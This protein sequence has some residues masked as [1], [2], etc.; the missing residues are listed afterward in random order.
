MLV[1][2]GAAARGPMRKV[3]VEAPTKLRRDFQRR[4]GPAACGGHPWVNCRL[5]TPWEFLWLPAEAQ[6]EVCRRNMGIPAHTGSPNEVWPAGFLK[7]SAT[8]E[9]RTTV[10]AFV[11]AIYRLTVPVDEHGTRCFVHERC[12]H[13]ITTRESGGWVMGE[14]DCSCGL[15]SF[16][17]VRWWRT[18][19]MLWQ[20]PAGWENFPS[21]YDEHTAA[22][23]DG[24]D[25]PEALRALYALAQP[26][27]EVPW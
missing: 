11:L 13:R 1:E 22:V 10:E 25:T 3:H 12:F 18:F 16:T 2:D 19:A 20:K 6:C 4:R 24:R 14:S 17:D 27:D 5:L 21:T 8:P 7:Y 9:M 23:G 26:S 15:V